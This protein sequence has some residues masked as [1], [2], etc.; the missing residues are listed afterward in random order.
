MTQT[1]VVDSVEGLQEVYDDIALQFG[2]MDFIEYLESEQPLLEDFHRER[3]ATQTDADGNQWKKNA[4]LTI[5]RKGHTRI[6]RGIPTEGH[7]LSR[8]LTQRLRHST[9]DAVREV[10]QSDTGAGLSFGTTRPYSGVNQRGTSRI[11]ARP[12][13]G[14]NE[15]YL[16]AMTERAVDYTLAQLAK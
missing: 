7:R 16:D 6:L 10:V 1:F 14:I 12:H 3:F 5:K 9:E 11:P 15:P 8:S 4:P 2:E 13:V